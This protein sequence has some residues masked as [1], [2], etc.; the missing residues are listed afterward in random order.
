MLL[1]KV[2]EQTNLIYINLNNIN[3][4]SLI[5]LDECGVTFVNQN[6]L[7][8]VGGKEANP[9]SWPASAYIQVKYKKRIT[10][11]TSSFVEDFEFLCG[12][13][14]IN[15]KTVLTA[16]HCILDSVE[17]SLNGRIFHEKVVPNEYYPTYASMYKVYLGFHDISSIK[18]S[19]TF[20]TG[21]QVDVGSVIRVEFYEIFLKQ[22]SISN[23]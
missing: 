23:Y 6:E 18:N 9:A 21:I 10:Y 17:A 4:I 14:L 19:I 16:A 20:T 2:F 15:R 12:G 5:V 1:E 7:K 8:I 11:G 13:N 22:Q 3:N